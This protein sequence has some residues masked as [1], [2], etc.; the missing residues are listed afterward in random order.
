[1]NRVLII[2]GDVISKNMGGVG[3]RNWEIAHALAQSCIVTLAI[4]N[5]TDLSSDYVKLHSFVLER[6]DLRPVAQ[7]ADVIII[8]GF[9]L[10]FHPY[11]SELGI[12]LAVD[13]YV[14]YLLE[15]LVWHGNKNVDDW[16]PAY[17]EY[18]RVQLES[19]RVGDFFYCASERQRDYWLGWLH[20]QKRINPHTYNADSSLNNL[21]SVVPFGIPAESP[22][23]TQKVLKGIHPCISNSDKL[24][25][26]SGGIW[27]WLD[28]LTV[29]QAMARLVPKHPE[30]KLYFM[31]VR[32]PNPAVSGMTMPERA[33]ALSREL[34]LYNEHV[35][36]GDW[37]PYQDR[38]NYLI[39]ADLAVVSHH[40]H[41]ETRFSFRT[42]ILDCIWADLP[43][44]ISKGDLMAEWIANAGIGLVVPPGD[45]ESTANAFH[46][47]LTKRNLNIEQVYGFQK[48]KQSLRWQECVRPLLSFCQKPY[49]AHDKGRYFTEVERM[50]RD[51]DVYIQTIVQDKERVIKQCSAR[52]TELQDS[53]DSLKQ[54]VPFATVVIVNYNGAHYLPACLDALKKQTYPWE[55]F[56]T[57]VVDNGSTDNS[58]D[59]L[60]Q[61]Y[62]WVR[63]LETGCNLGFSGGNNAA[64]ETTSADYV[65]L[66]NN[67]TAP[68]PEWLESLVRVAEQN[69][70][71]GLVT[72]RL[73]LFYDQLP[74]ELAV[75][76]FIPENDRRCLG[77]QIFSIDS[78]IRRGVVQFLDGFYGWEHR[79][80]GQA[81]RWTTGQARLGIPISQGEEPILIRMQLA[82]PR[83]SGAPVMV[84]VR[85]GGE[86]V[87]QWNITNVPQEFEVEIPAAARRLAQTL[88]QNAG[89]YVSRN[90]A[91]RDRGTYVV[92][93][94]LFYEVDT[95]QY[96]S[97]EEVF[98]GCGASLLVRRSL[99]YQIGGLDDEFFMYYEDTDLSWRARL[100]GWKVLYAPKAK[101][102]HIHCGT[103]EEWSPF[104]VYL[105]DRNRLAMLFKNGSKRQILKEWGLYA[106]ET[107]RNLGRVGSHLLH[108]NPDWRK[109]AKRSHIQFRVF[110]RLLQWMPSLLGKRRRIQQLRRLSC[111]EVE[112]WF[113]DDI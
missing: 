97:I 56:D 87:A 39:E 110:A 4:P 111:D 47:L 74:L 13:L 99:L 34:G 6:D 109:F 94:D 33:E 24:I 26:W 36:F 2:S 71:S 38:V 51:K 93:T 95:D 101:V 88:V 67:D 72:G 30:Y 18:L 45:V 27:D 21:I 75:Q 105:T 102:R 70:Q 14:P 73:Q 98:A 86:I 29:I 81:F 8:H 28:P 58:V 52:I 17:E 85:L 46:T 83:P 49:H 53:L 35:F 61:L 15:G 44:V 50:S 80:D 113:S 37:I 60:R 112:N 48:F 90:G 84:E 59:L 91:G 76:P 55:R 40:N 65:V 62:P 68:S 92:G 66:L 107:I 96:N 22:V 20:A 106:A 32:H 108:R 89:S 7:D 82:A 64:I 16:V 57:I 42:R 10:H 54:L 43:I 1:M 5:E 100:A 19:L 9:I 31:G 3:I 11:L 12:P 103:T 25:L 63:I 78:G 69:P 77:M 41:I 104:F 23:A 79:P